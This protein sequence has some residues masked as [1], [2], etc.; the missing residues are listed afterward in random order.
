VADALRTELAMVKG[1]AEAAHEGHQEQRKQ[2]ASEAHRAVERFTTVQAKRDQA[3][4]DS[5]KAREEAATL[6]GQLDVVKEQ[7][8]Q[9]LQT[10]KIQGEKQTTKSK[11]D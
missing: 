11:N 1:K 3:Q 6:R 4:K 9:L 10:L 7:N 2:A 5:R 8:A